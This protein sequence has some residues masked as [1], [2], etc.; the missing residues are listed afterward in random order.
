MHRAILTT[1]VGETRLHHY[2]F[3]LNK[4][5]NKEGWVLEQWH[6]RSHHEQRVGCPADQRAP[7]SHVDS[8]GVREGVK[9]QPRASTASK[10]LQHLW[11]PQAQQQVSCRVPFQGTHILLQWERRQSRAFTFFKF[12]LFF[13]R[14]TWKMESTTG[15][16]F[17]YISVDARRIFPLG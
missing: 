14:Q 11:L 1:S 7:F 2:T 13:R 8:A 15:C 9:G 6:W 5:K 3:E 10:N 16:S 4:R 17:S 12:R